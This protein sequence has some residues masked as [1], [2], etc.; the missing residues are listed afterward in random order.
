MSE[1][2]LVPDLIKNLQFV[3][4]SLGSIS[5]TQ[6]DKLE[7]SLLKIAVPMTFLGRYIENYKAS[8]A[9]HSSSL[10]ALNEA[11]HREDIAR[12]RVESML[13]HQRLSG[14]AAVNSST[15]VPQPAFPID[16]EDNDY[17]SLP[18]SN[19]E[20]NEIQRTTN[21]AQLEL[22]QAESHCEEMKTEEQNILRFIRKESR[23]IQYI[24]RH[25]ILV[26]L[27]NFFPSFGS[28]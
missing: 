13:E 5:Q 7:K 22:C 9:Q 21:E 27:I 25:Q 8:V 11:H 15:S 17:E 26:C 14:I 4:S 19:F 1:F 23:R 28:V 10:N 16:E 24:Q 3:S 12:K 18:S 2:E 20:I 6:Q